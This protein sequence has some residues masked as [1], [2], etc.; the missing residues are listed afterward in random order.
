MVII[1]NL[2]EKWDALDENVKRIIMAISFLVI[3]ILLAWLVYMV[4]FAPSFVSPPPPPE[5]KTGELP[6]EVPFDE[7]PDIGRVPGTGVG[8]LPEEEAEPALYEALKADD[9]AKGGL[10]TTKFIYNKPVYSPTISADKQGFN[11]YDKV[12]GKFYRIPAGGGKP[13][14]LSDKEFMGVENVTWSP[15]GNRAIIEF[16]DGSNILYNFINGAQYTL[17]KEGVDFDFNKTGE[18]IGYKY[19]TEDPEDNWIVVSEPDGRNARAVEELADEV[20]NVDINW[21]PSSQIVATFRKGSDLNEQEV[22]FIG[23]NRENFQKFQTPGRGFKGEWSPQGNKMLYSVYLEE[24]LF[25][26]TIHVVSAHPN[27]IG[28]EN[29]NL[30]VETIVEKCVF[31]GDNINVY[32]AVPVYMPRGAGLYPELLKGV[33]DDIYQINTRTGLRKKL[34][35]PVGES[36]VGSFTVSQI[37]LSNDEKSLYLVDESNFLRELKIKE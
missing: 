7:T 31:S 10:T 14:A 20:Y 3:G 28:T 16:L 9:I 25:R 18:D 26:P 34:A 24:D 1:D 19:V 27:N 11:Y 4:F 32:C 33:P 13:S 5:R 23:K 17:P 36:G 8:T 21:S 30:E 22:Y 6:G 12:T 15:E 2:R 37:M 35:V 29:K